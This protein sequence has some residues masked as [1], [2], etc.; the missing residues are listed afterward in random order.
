[1]IMPEARSFVGEIIETLELH[2]LLIKQ[3]KMLK[4]HA[5]AHGG[6]VL[7]LEDKR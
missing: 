4:L 7:Q 6:L 5:G 1:M 3:L 2:K